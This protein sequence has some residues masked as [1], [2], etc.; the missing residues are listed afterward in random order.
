[1]LFPAQ[2]LASAPA[3]V[4]FLRRAAAEAEP[5]TRS[6]AGSG[7]DSRGSV[8]AELLW[9]LQALA[10]V[11]GTRAPSAVSPAGLLHALRRARERPQP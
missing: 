5:G 2:A 7:S 11:P 4:E 3:L 8:L 6:H 10:P 9:V 1:M